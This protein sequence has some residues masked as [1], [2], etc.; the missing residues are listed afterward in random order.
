MIIVA[1]MLRDLESGGSEVGMELG[2]LKDPWYILHDVGGLFPI[3][4]L[5][6]PHLLSPLIEGLHL[7][8][9]TGDD[10]IRRSWVPHSTRG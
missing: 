6:V 3:P 4:H 5:H 9:H 2:G 10:K 1:V 7:P 8:P